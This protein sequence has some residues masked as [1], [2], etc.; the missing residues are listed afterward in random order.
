MKAEP[1]LTA[2]PRIGALA[3]F[4]AV[5]M[6]VEAALGT[7][8]RHSF[9]SQRASIAYEVAMAVW[10]LRQLE[11]MGVTSIGASGRQATDIGLR[12]RVLLERACMR[13]GALRA[14]GAPRRTTSLGATSVN[15]LL[16]SLDNERTNAEVTNSIRGILELGLTAFII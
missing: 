7:L 8:V 3:S 16:A 5:D 2:L 14:A 6:E 10:L 9:A 13:L 11:L 1:L 15:R 4:G 12:L